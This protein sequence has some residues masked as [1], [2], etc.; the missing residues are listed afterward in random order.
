MHDVIVVGGSAGALEGVIRLVQGLPDTLEA[1]MHVVLHAGESGL[2][3][4][5]ALL[6]GRTPLKIRVAEPGDRIRHG[7]VYLPQ[8]DH[9]LMLGR[10][11][12][13]VNRG[14]K[15]NR[16]RPAIDPLF[17]SAAAAYGPRVVGILLSGFLDDGVHGLSEIRRAGGETIVQDPEEAPVPTL[18]LNAL[19]A[20]P[21]DHVAPST[22]MS[23]LVEKLSR[24]AA[25]QRRGGRPGPF[26]ARETAVLTAA[27]TAIPK[28]PPSPFTCPECDG[29]LWQTHDIPLMYS[30]H[31]G[32]RFTAPS[33]R[34]GQKEAGDAHL[35]RAVRSHEEQAEMHRRWAAL[36]GERKR[37]HAIDPKAVDIRRHA[38]ALENRALILRRIIM[39]RTPGGKAPRRARASGRSHRVTR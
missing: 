9:H 39:E 31:V 19:R 17:T 10:G 15:Q 20:F 22:R 5:P 16:F 6:K 18:P 2:A 38:E 21:V 14:P 11:R 37:S 4:V 30:C 32:H 3:L 33:L 8:P 26:A 34:A 29:S 27:P 1:S 13:V 23:G 35:W 24:A 12:L 7:I 28:S 25:K 36:E